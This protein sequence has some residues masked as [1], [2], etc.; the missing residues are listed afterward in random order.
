MSED[1]TAHDRARRDE[2]TETSITFV[3]TRD[4]LAALLLYISR[5]PIR[6][7]LQALI[8]AGIGAYFLVL[9]MLSGLVSAVFEQTDGVF[10]AI[11]DYL[12]TK[13]VG[14]LRPV[15]PWD[16]AFCGGLFVLN[17]LVLLPRQCR[18]LARRS[19]AAYPE[20]R[21]DDPTMALTNHVRVDGRGVEGATRD[22]RIFVTW[23]MVVRLVERRDRFYVMLSRSSAFILP[24][25]AL[26][27]EA[28]R[29]VLDAIRRSLATS[30]AGRR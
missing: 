1:R 15:A 11:L 14:D 5:S 19:L 21:P 4:D 9:T 17:L 20:V 2:T 27:D 6:I 26:A 7:A 10:G 18:L 30:R 28:G 29:K 16:I 25:S 12:R 22:E 8:F 23:P 24:K 13:A 3:S